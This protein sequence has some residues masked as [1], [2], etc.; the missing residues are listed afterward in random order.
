MGVAMI[1]KLLVVLI[2]LSWIYWLIACYCTWRFF[3]EQA[4]PAREYLPPVSIL[5]PVKGLDFSAREN[6]ASFMRQDYPTYEVL[7][8]V[9]D[10]SDVAIAEIEGVRRAFPEVD[11]R[12]VM[13]SAKG[14][15]PKVAILQTLADASRYEVLVVSDSD[16][17]VAPDYLRRVVAPLADEGLG[18]VTCPYRGAAPLTLT[19]RLEALYIG[20][21]F[22]PSVM[23]ARQY[24]DMRFA[25]GATM[26]LR[27]EDL[28]RAGGF[29]AVADCLA[30]DYQ[31]GAAIA[32]TGKRVALSDYMVSIHLGPTTFR[33]QWDREVRWARC[34]SVS[35]PLEY[36]ALWLTYSTA[37][38]VILVL[39]LG[40][41]ALAWAPLGVSLL[42][43]WA[44]GWWVTGYTGEEDLR[45]WLIWLPL[46]DML[47]ALV[48]FAGATGRR[49]VWR[50][51]RYI[52]RADGRME[53]VPRR[54]RVSLARR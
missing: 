18:M 8:G 26:A 46:R 53:P 21:T 39:V 49:V 2:V 54:E 11:V 50:G 48:W 12:L 29:A 25:L 1:A 52:V 32:A 3:R 20:V 33:E 24:L 45:R 38:G 34:A 27:R 6:W 13:A 43:R 42:L 35:R 4:R 36:P 14:A 19:A 15:N 22:L 9:A 40:S 51:E 30:D 47:S 44:V 16:V 37:L 10:P 7:F 17:R 31:L 28:T 41:G 23:V 5:K